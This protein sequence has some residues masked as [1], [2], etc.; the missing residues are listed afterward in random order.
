MLNA[1]KIFKI[2]FDNVCVTLI[3]L[4]LP[5]IC[6]A[7]PL[8]LL[9]KKSNA[10]PLLK[11]KSNPLLLTLLK[12]SNFF[13]NALQVTRYIVKH[14]FSTIHKLNLNAYKDIS[15]NF[16]YFQQVSNYV[17]EIGFIRIENLNSSDW[18]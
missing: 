2:T 1:F 16:I 9:L 18:N 7:L 5:N 10:L 14:C 15:S 13:S 6:N 8:P 4:P 12:N 11:K 3:A 17:F